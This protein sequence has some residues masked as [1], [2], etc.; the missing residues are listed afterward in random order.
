[1]RSYRFEFKYEMPTSTARLVELAVKNFGMVLDKNSLSANG[2]Y[3]VTSLYFDSYNFGD[4]F[5]KTGGF[6]NRKKIRVRIYEPYLSNSEKVWIEIKNK[7]ESKNSK[8]RLQLS[9]E[10]AHEFFRSGSKFLLSYPWKEKD[11]NR[12]DE[13]IWNLARA[14]ARPRVMVRYK[15][16]ALV[17]KLKS[18]RV[19]FDS[20]I[21]TCKRSNLLYDKFM[22]PVTR[23]T[24]VMEVKYD[25]VLPAW[26]K[27]IIRKYSLKHDTFSKYERSLEVIHR[28]NP[29]LR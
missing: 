3:T 25:Y 19:T 23:N 29:L 9:R 16:L 22:L 18:L 11:K 12:K 24:V 20:R 13:L 17:N 5:E 8:T 27:T 6:I 26:F 7:Y 10:Q 21:E 4:Y 28:Y 2:T 15:R 1:M 14:N